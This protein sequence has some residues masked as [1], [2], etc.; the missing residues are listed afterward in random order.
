MPRFYFDYRA[1]DELSSDSEGQEMKD[2]DAARTGAVDAL[3]AMARGMAYAPRRK[4]AMS[5]RDAAKRP[6]FT[7]SLT[8][9]MIEDA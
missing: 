6:L 5:V 9:E 8:F 1:G 7:A 2:A 4:I 3:M